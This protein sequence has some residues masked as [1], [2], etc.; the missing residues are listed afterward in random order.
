VGDCRSALAIACSVLD[1]IRNAGSVMLTT[2]DGQSGVNGDICRDY[3]E[4]VLK[5]APGLRSGFI[6]SLTI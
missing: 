4:Q 1:L 3:R 5:K 6:G 2:S